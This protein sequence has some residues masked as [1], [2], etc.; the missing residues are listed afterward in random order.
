MGFDREKAKAQTLSHE[1]LFI[2]LWTT[3]RRNLFLSGICCCRGCEGGE[4]LTD[5]PKTD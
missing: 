1:E 2:S 4:G 3:C 5:A